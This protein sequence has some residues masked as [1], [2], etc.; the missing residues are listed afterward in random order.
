MKAFGIEDHATDDEVILLIKDV[1]IQRWVEWG[2]RILPLGSILQQKHS[3]EEVE[4]PDFPVT[5]L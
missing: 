4:A 1:K 3:A 2:V 5:S